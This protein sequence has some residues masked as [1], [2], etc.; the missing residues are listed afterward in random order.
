MSNTGNTNKRKSKLRS[1]KQKTSKTK[2]KS[3]TNKSKSKTNKSKTS[4][5]KSKTKTKSKTKS[6]TN[7]S[8][9]KDVSKISFKSDKTR[10]NEDK[11][12]V[13]S[14]RC[15]ND[16]Y[17]KY[18]IIKN[19]YSDVEY[20]KNPICNFRMVDNTKFYQNKKNIISI[21]F[22]RMPNHY[23]NFWIYMQGLKRWIQFMRSF[24]HDYVIRMFIDINI[25]SDPSIM[26]IIRK[27]KH[28]EPVLFLCNNY[29][30]NGYHTD[31]FGT[32]VRFFPAFNFKNN[33]ARNVVVA[34]ID[35]HDEDII[36]LKYIME[37][38]QPHLTISGIGCITLNL[39]ENKPLYLFAG[40]LST[41]TIS[42][43]Y[44]QNI[45]LKFI[46]NIKH[47]KDTGFYGE[48]KTDF[49]FGVDEIFLNK[50]W[51]PNSKMH[52]ASV[53]YT[54]SYFIFHE[55]DKMGLLSNPKTNRIFKKILGKYYKEGM[56]NKEMYE[57]FDKSTYNLAGFNEQSYYL[58]KRLYDII[59][60]LTDKNIKWLH[61]KVSNYLNNELYYVKSANVFFRANS[62]KPTD[63]ICHVENA[64]KLKHQ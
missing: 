48:R 35:L 2:T 39:Y 7:K 10:S 21:A 33:D 47:L 51:I 23:K 16:D 38:K 55:V 40:S 42:G 50:S 57:L 24:K 58:S 60:E 32:L 5:S 14:V 4:K 26:K 44:D 34:D 15:Q 36:R 19:T 28:I 22:F 20:L 12:L 53:Q 56:T 37:R 11:L 64:V 17:K 63:I 52:E 54:P 61:P 62:D 59:R 46:K 1:T 13:Q 6:K 27:S 31:L 8:S 41:G 18:E 30:T 9:F 45:I 43:Y 3:K 25:Y 49:G 29:Q